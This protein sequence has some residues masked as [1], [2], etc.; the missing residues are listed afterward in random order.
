M[1]RWCVLVEAARQE[2]LKQPNPKNP[3][4]KNIEYNVLKQSVRY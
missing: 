4:L 2:G 1:P 3:T